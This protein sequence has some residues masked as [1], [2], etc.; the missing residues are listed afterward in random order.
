MSEESAQVTLGDKTYTV[1]PQRIGRIQRRLRE[2]FELLSGG[3][4]VEDVGPRLREALEVF[5][6]DIDPIWRLQ[7]YPS[8]AAAKRDQD[9]RVAEEKRREEHAKKWYDEQPADVHAELTAAP[10]FEHLPAQVQAEYKPAPAPEGVYEEAS[11]NSPTPPQLIN[12]IETIF[13]IHGGERF[14]N[15]VGKVV[16]GDALQGM[17]ERQIVIW[18]AQQAQ[19]ASLLSQ[20]LRV[21]TGGSASTSS[22]TPEPTESEIPSDSPQLASSTS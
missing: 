5:I 2:V 4:D 13:R 16:S 10:P 7:G 21:G 15:L 19:Q 20:S 12:V 8:E 22:T 14:L 6:P 1:V 9:Y 17:V 11:D 3:T 18:Q